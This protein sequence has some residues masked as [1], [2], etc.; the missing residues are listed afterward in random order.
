[1]GPGGL[2]YRTSP[3]W[4]RSEGSGPPLLVRR[5]PSRRRTASLLLQG[6]FLIFAASSACASANVRT[7]AAANAANAL[8]VA[9]VTEDF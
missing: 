3:I 4:N 1:M 8:G 9:A 2:G 6:L 7:I 5:R